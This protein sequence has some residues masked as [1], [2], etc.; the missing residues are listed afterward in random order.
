MLVSYSSWLHGPI[1]ATLLKDSLIPGAHYPFITYAKENP[2]SS[3]P[4][5]FSV[6]GCWVDEAAKNLRS[7]ILM[8]IAV[9]FLPIFNS[10]CLYP[11][12]HDSCDKSSLPPLPVLANHLL[13]YLESYSFLQ[14]NFSTCVRACL[15]PTKPSSSLL[16]DKYLFLKF[17]YDHTDLCLMPYFPFCLWKI[18]R[19]LFKT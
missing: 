12:F 6:Q 1:L 13:I 3:W 9:L 4:T 17:K 15:A 10:L 19:F 11:V 7:L 18:S 16:P 2:M 8:Y 5:V 14:P